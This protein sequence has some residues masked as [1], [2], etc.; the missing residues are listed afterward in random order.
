MKLKVRFSPGVS[1]LL[2]VK[3][4][5]INKRIG[6]AKIYE[7][8]HKQLWRKY[9][10]A[11]TKRITLRYLPLFQ[12]YNGRPVAFIS[13][14]N[15]KSSGTDP[16]ARERKP[17]AGYIDVVDDGY[18]ACLGLNQF[19][20]MGDN[21][22]DADRK[23]EMT[24]HYDKEYPG[25]PGKNGGIYHDSCYI[26]PKTIQL[27]S[28]S[29][30]QWMYTI[31]DGDWSDTVAFRDRSP[32]GAILVTS[33]VVELKEYANDNG[34][35]SSW[36]V[37]K[38]TPP[39]GDP[40]YYKM[41][42]DEGYGLGWYENKLTYGHSGS[43][44]V[45][46]RDV[47]ETGLATAHQGLRY[48]LALD[49]AEY[50]LEEWTYT[51]TS[52]SAAMFGGSSGKGYIMLFGDGTVVEYV[53]HHYEGGDS[54]LFEQAHYKLLPM[55]Y[56][57]TG[58]LAMPRKDFVE[59]WGELFG[60]VVHEKR[61]VLERIATPIIAIV[62]VVVAFYTAGAM[63]WGIWGALVMAGGV[64]TALGVLGGDQ[65]MLALGSILSIIGGIGSLIKTGLSSAV[66]METEYAGTLART[67]GAEAIKE[68]TVSSGIGALFDNMTSGSGMMNLLR[69]GKGTFDL[70]QHIETLGTDKEAAVTAIA[71]D[72]NRIE[73]EYGP[74]ALNE[75]TAEYDVPM[76]VV[77][78][79][80][81][82]LRTIQE[83]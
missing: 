59:K 6:N 44:Y 48:R 63:G 75:Y 64:F 31:F 35:M 27:V 1:P 25:H 23:S 81:D 11:P 42:K 53:P 30:R 70:F 74:T 18:R 77:K 46:D 58:D 65:K 68:T 80:V 71:E 43:S 50:P 72:T 45:L 52:S 7:L 17:Q 4:A 39:T 47:Y 36:V 57:D 20:R 83:V 3:A 73:A 61:S 82:I 16:Y 5:V 49:G 55:V 79:H 10:D 24:F 69:I 37:V 15:I 66:A 78:P 8:L 33:A 12:Y 22:P 32:T 60:L 14:W 38:C 34:T 29:I 2:S 9:V 40:I 56:T 28:D 13:S 21:D 62:A 67:G 76:I 54:G 41:E 19:F 51:N 26:E